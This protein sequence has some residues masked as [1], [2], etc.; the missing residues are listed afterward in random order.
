METILRTCPVCGVEYQAD[1]KRLKFGRQTTCS[2]KCSYA[3]RADIRDKSVELVCGVCG[4][5]FTRTPAQVARAKHGIFCSR[6]CHY[7]ARGLG[8]TKRVV[9]NPYTYTPESKAAMIAASS[10]P[11]GKRTFHLL[12]CAQCGK[13][14]DDPT[15][16]RKRKSGVS[17]CSLDCCNAYRKGENNPAW[18][19]GHPKYYGAD[20]RGLRRDARSRDKYTCQ[21]C[22][23]ECTSPQR[24]PDVHHIKPVSSFDN[25]NDANTLDNVVCL[26]HTCHMQVEWNGIDFDWPK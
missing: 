26:C 13:E 16:G 1:T 20:W 10:K 24:A 3:L 14:F 8:L 5:K 9:E 12:E 2:R 7:A 21:R 18:R 11:K 22:G 25:V 23:K 4:E 17:F 19:G 15:D 6:E